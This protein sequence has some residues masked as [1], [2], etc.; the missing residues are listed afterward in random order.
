MKK[1]FMLL[2]DYAK[3]RYHPLRGVD[4]AITGMLN[5]MFET[6]DISITEDYPTLTLDDLRKYNLIINYIDTWDRAN[7]DFAGALLGYIAAG[8]RLL[9]L[10]SGIIAHSLPE[11]EQLVGACF[12]E[13][14]PREPLEYTLAEAHPITRGL[15]PFTIDE[16]PYKFVMDNLARVSV[17]MEYTYKGE[18]FPAAWTRT[19][20]SGKSCYLSMGHE[21][22]SFA[23]EGF[24]KL[25]KRSLLWC[26][27]EL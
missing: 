18:K 21:A 12:T 27:E 9:T 5:D 15:E 4:D 1:H 24:V 19:Y 11:I 8:G 16:E 14:P 13:H 2:G 10:H 22:A 20:G 26:M 17:F 23:N 7:A 6:Y 3:P 25:I